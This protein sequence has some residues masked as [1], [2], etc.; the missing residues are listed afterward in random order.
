MLR[1]SQRTCRLGEK[2]AGK[3]DEEAD[4]ITLRVE[5]ANV[6]LDRE[7]LNALLGEPHAY[8]ALYNTS[9]TP[10]TP[11]LKCLKALELRN[12]WEGAYVAL[13]YEMGKRKIEFK[14]AKISKIKIEPRHGGDTFLSLTVEGEPALDG[15]FVDIIARVG[16]AAECEIRADR[17]ED[18]RDLPLN[19]HDGA[20]PVAPGRRPHAKTSRSKRAH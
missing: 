7:E 11:Y 9:A 10:V 4:A 5:L 17:P 20:R 2:Y 1:I 18:Q 6:V 16:G 15:K 3:K 14:R 8:E 13:W 12:S 19:S